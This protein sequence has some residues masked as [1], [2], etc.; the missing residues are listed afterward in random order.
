MDKTYIEFVCEIVR[1]ADVGMPVYTKRIAPILAKNAELDETAAAAAVAVAM[2]RIQERTLIPELRMHQK[3]IYYRSAQT[4][5]GEVGINKEQLIADKYLLPNKG[6]ETGL[7]ILHQMGL[8][9]QM[10]KERVLATNVAKACAR[11][12]HRLG[13]VVRPPKVSINTRNKDYLQVLDVL[14]MLD[15]A[16]ID[17]ENPHRIIDRHIRDRGLRYDVLLALA[18]Q[19]YNKH[20]VLQLAHTAREGNA[21]L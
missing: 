18:D 5:F 20:T 6:Y 16:P 11:T 17:A 2:R 13:V 21:M 1:Q 12:D 15:Q 19:Y 3:G 9:T 10:P 14:D 7:A 4:V 8:S